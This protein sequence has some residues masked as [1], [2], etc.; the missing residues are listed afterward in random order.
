MCRPAARQIRLDDRDHRH[1]HLEDPRNDDDVA[2][3]SRQTV[4]AFRS[5]P[6]AITPTTT[7]T[8]V[9]VNSLPNAT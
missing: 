8:V 7:T 4:T 1:R 9:I 2:S 6:A 5:S 3:I